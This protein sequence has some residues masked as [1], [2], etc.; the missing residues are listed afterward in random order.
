M[1]EHKKSL[2]YTKT[3]DKGFTS[4]VGGTR[5]IKSDLRLDAYGTIDELNSFLG[6]L[7]CEIGV[8]E[9]KEQF[10]NIQKKLFTIGSIL[11]TENK[12]L[13][14]KYGLQVKQEEIR[15]LEMMI[16]EIDSKLPRM[17]LFVLPGGSKNGAL[18]HVCRTICRRAER[19]IIA[20]NSE[21][22]IDDNL[23]VYINRLSDLLFVYARKLSID[24]NNKEI[25]WDTKSE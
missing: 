7:I 4:L 19:Q 17:K 18:A 9:E 12:E 15:S 20:L 11:A 21:T 22:E 10:I 6:L 2:V 8:F 24:E 3:G 13:S 5:I 16:D 25:F 23:V 1:S 14:S